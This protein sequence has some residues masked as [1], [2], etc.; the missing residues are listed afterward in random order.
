[1]QVQGSLLNESRPLRLNVLPGFFLLPR[2]CNLLALLICLSFTVRLCVQLI[3]TAPARV[4]A[5]GGCP[6]LV[7]FEGLDVGL[8]RLLFSAMSIH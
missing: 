6:L 1:M 3:V 4:A 2:L 5:F 7:Q 8:K